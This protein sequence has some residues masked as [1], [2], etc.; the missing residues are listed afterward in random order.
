MSP[1][2]IRHNQAAHAAANGA[3]AHVGSR[4]AAIGWSNQRWNYGTVFY[5]RIL[6]YV[7]GKIYGKI[8]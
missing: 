4:E 2:Q 5:H 1:T 7:Y 3:T 6:P 8:C